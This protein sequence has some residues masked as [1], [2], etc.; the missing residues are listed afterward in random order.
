M[1]KDDAA[2]L[3]YIANRLKVGHVN[4]WSHFARFSVTSQKDLRVI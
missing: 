2:M 3:N 4:I 1:H